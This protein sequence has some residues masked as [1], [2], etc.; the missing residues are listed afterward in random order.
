M[1][2]VIIVI[3]LSVAGVAGDYFIK[4][5][6]NSGKAVEI[7]WFL[8]GALIYASTAF[9]WLYAMKHIKLSSLGAIYSLTTVLLLVALGVLYF[10]EQLNACEML[11]IAAAITAIILLSKFI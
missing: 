2:T 3:A 11:G 9:G 7:K 1:N 5:A 10:H 4:I 8:I 6:G